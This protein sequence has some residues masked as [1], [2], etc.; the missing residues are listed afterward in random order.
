M[1]LPPPDPVFVDAF[2]RALG[3]WQHATRPLVLGTDNIPD[4]RPLMFVGNHT[5]WGLFDTP[6]L[7]AE[8][9]QRKRILPR[10]LGDHVHWQIPL[11]RDVLTRL[12]VVDGTRQSARELLRAG[13]CLLVFP[14]GG[15]EVAKRRGEKYR[16]LWKDRVGFAL[17][18]IR[19]GATVVPVSLLGGEEMLDIKVDANDLLG[20]PVLGD[21]VRRLPMRH[22]VIIPWARGFAGLPLPRPERLYFR[23]GAPLDARDHLP[24]E[25]GARALRDLVKHSVQDGLR[26]LADERARDPLR[27]FRARAADAAMGWVA[28][29]LGRA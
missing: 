13:E 29:L 25:A 5:I 6:V 22:D 3:P 20:A 14:G 10:A 28:G 9:W 27:R 18:A 15:R 8:L 12:G 19:H 7:L 23:F 26:E 1:T 21:L 24:T 16:L 2:F 17:L 4:R 11:W